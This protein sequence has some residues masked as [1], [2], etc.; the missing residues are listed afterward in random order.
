MSR[1]EQDGDR[2]LLKNALYL[3]GEAANLSNSNHEA[4]QSFAR[5]QREFFP[6]SG[7]LPEFLL[8]VGVRGMVSLRA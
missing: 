1:A 6:N 8:A 2:D 4:R 3:Q 7:H 5:L